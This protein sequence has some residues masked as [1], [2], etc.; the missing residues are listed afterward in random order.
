MRIDSTASL[1][2]PAFADEAHTHSDHGPSEEMG[3]V[4]I[5]CNMAVHRQSRPTDDY[6]VAVARVTFAQGTFMAGTAT[7]HMIGIGCSKA[8]PVQH[9]ID[10]KRMNHYIAPGSICL[11][12]AEASHSTLFGGS[13]SGIALRVSPECLSLVSA[14]YVGHNVDLIKQINGRDGFIAHVAH[15]LDGE[16]NAGHPNGVLFWHSV[17]DA[18]LLHLVKNHTN[19]QPTLESGQLAL[20]TVN[21]I[22]SFIIENLSEPLTL[23]N[24]SAVAGCTRFQFA[25]FFRATVGVSPYRYVVR[26]RLESAR[27]M[28]NARQ[29]TL[30]EI[31]AATGFTDQS[32]MTKWIKRVYGATPSQLVVKFS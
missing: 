13:M 12:P 23:D 7:H 21:R 6:G 4:P 16:A 28:I 26:R 24:L 19:R 31:S 17:T 20:A 10:G 15:V 14:E 8:T 3:T 30:A 9:M 1:K 29:G 32:H 18:L 27:A 25:R 22:N 5:H 2:T 11:C